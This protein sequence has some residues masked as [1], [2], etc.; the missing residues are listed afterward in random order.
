LSP[1][2]HECLLASVLFCHHVHV[3]A[4]RYTL[5][6]MPP[7]A[8][9][10]GAFFRAFLGVKGGLM[11]TFYSAP[12]DPSEG[13]LDAAPYTRAQTGIVTT[14]SAFT[15]SS[16]YAAARFHGFFKAGGA[17]PNIVIASALSRSYIKGSQVVNGW[18]TAAGATVTDATLACVSGQYI[19]LFQETRSATSGDSHTLLKFATGDL[20]TSN[21]FAAVAISN[22]PVPLTVTQS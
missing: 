13:S 5:T 17:C 10:A 6:T 1:F 20:G 8:A 7:G 11:A 15:C 19:E 16:C 22:T 4:L 9:Y 2:S 3:V 14:S 21:L 18:S 12:T